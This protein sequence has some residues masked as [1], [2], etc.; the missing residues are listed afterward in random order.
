MLFIP[1]LVI[2][3]L[4]VCAFSSCQRGIIGL[5]TIKIGLKILTTYFFTFISRTFLFILDIPEIQQKKTKDQR[6]HLWSC[7]S[8]PS[9]CQRTILW[10]TSYQ[11]RQNVKM[12]VRRTI[13]RTDLVKVG[14]I[15]FLGNVNVTARF[16]HPTRTESCFGGVSAA[17]TGG[18]VTS[19]AFP[20]DGE[21]T[22]SATDDWEE[23]LWK[24]SLCFLHRWD[25]R[26][27]DISRLVA[28]THTL[29]RIC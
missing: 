8:A 17:Q 4:C 5:T 15:F 14:K 29:P 7:L 23:D 13:W 3:F 2:H 16:R 19:C 22:F 24:V 11:M 1:L 25:H 28:L 6:E 10:R 18:N 21:Q 27:I 26:W 20:A 12:S 9:K